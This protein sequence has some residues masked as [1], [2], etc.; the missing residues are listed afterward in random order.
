MAQQGNPTEKSGLREKLGL[1]L[2]KGMIPETKRAQIIKALEANP[3]AVAV[4]RE[5][6]VSKGSVRSIAKAAK[7][8]LGKSGPKKVTPEKRARIIEALETNP[9]A[10]AVAREIGGITYA[11]V[12]RLAHKANITLRRTVTPEKRA[13]IIEALEANP[14]ASAVARE[15][16]GI[17]QSAVSKLAR[18]ANITLRRKGN[19]QTIKAASA[20]RN[21]VRK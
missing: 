18:K 9:N 14:N 3:N 2:I 17:S 16:G 5:Y 10:S 13:R 15:I 11:A 20:A 1:C 8:D 6:G 4:A 12:S 7:I 21:L 19:R